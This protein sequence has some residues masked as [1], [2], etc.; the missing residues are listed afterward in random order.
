MLKFVLK[1]IGSGILVIWGITSLLFVIFNLLGNPA[2]SMTDENT[3]AA[4]RAAIE[5][6]YHLDR[7]LGMQYLFYLNDLSPLGFLDRSNP[8]TSEIGHI[9]IFGVGGSKV[10][11]LKKPWMRRSF[12]SNRKVTTLLAEK[13]RGTAILALAAMTFAVALGIPLG[14]ISALK[15]GRWPDR[16]I[17]FLTL[18]GISAPSFFIAV[19]ILR[20]FAVDLGHITGLHV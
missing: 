19:L 3:D 6:A 11:A 20:I 17:S 8:E 9:S 18:L 10:L 14:M 16:L 13:L 4:T 5:K 7:S 2:E 12:Q 15:K 1:R